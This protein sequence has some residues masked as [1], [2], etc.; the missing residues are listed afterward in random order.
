MDFFA[1]G[2]PGDILSMISGVSGL[3]QDSSA[4][5]LSSLDRAVAELEASIPGLLRGVPAG[6]PQ[7]IHQEPQFYGEHVTIPSRVDYFKTVLP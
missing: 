6:R 7:S 4:L 3:S 2:L 5:T 1:A